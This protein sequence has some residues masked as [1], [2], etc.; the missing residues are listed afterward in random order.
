MKFV[1]YVVG[2]DVSTYTVCKFNVADTGRKHLLN[3]NRILR[4]RTVFLA[5]RAKSKAA[6]IFIMKI[7]LL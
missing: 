2:V 4:I 5:N 6:I 7:S 1:F 3:K